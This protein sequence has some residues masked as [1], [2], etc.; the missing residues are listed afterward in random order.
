M[1]FALY[2]HER[3]VRLTPVISA[4]SALFTLLVGWTLLGV[5]TRL[6]TSNGQPV[7]DAEDA[8]L[9]LLL[10]L[11]QTLV[12][13]LPFLPVR[14]RVQDHERS[15]PVTRRTLVVVRI[16]ATWTA[17]VV[18]LLVSSGLILM[19][20]R[21]EGHA[22]ALLLP[23]ANLVCALTLVV[24]LAFAWK[25]AKER[26]SIL[27]TLGLALVAALVVYVSL[28][29]GLQGIGLLYLAASLVAAF[30]I[31]RFVPA[32]TAEDPAA[33]TTFVEDVGP[34]REP[35]LSPLTRTILKTTALRPFN[36][37]A[38]FF[39]VVC[40]GLI[41]VDNPVLMLW[42][43]I[44]LPIHVLMRSLTLL[45]GFDALPIARARLFPWIA[46]PTL[47]ALVV[48][49]LLMGV[50]PHEYRSYD[51]VANAVELDSFSEDALGAEG[52]YSLHVRTPPQLWQ[53][54]TT[55][56]ARLV[57]APW[58]ESFRPLPHAVLWG[59]PLVVF[60]PYD[61]GPQSSV[62]FLTWQLAR[63]LSVAH[64]LHLTPEDIHARWF[65]DLHPDTKLDDVKKSGLDP[66]PW[67]ALTA[68]RGTTSPRKFGSLV[69]LAV[70][71]WFLSTA[72]V[73]RRNVPARTLH[74]W[75]RARTRRIAMS[76]GLALVFVLLFAFTLRDD[77]LL[78]VLGALAHRS[79]DLALGTS[80]WAWVG[81][82]LVLAVVASLVLVWRLN[83][84]EVPPL[85]R[86]GWKKCEVSVF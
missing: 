42:F 10:P 29:G 57:E 36:V 66:Q 1:S 19:R 70:F 13:V 11:L 68:A 21:G 7:F 80:A 86:T 40:I 37:T 72:W 3:V 18:P 55:A 44:A 58:G 56:D 64:G 65:A 15:L 6:E 77:A 79:L 53:L 51:P 50:F 69:A 78:P 33:D 82:D 4:L 43:P 38:L 30:V 8:L 41:G 60:N 85:P 31:H 63:A 71:F 22:G 2:R 59:A 76:L 67:S 9:V 35:L 49:F 27:E 62:R 39:L 47:A 83:R 25:P 75:R 17:L 46:L 54:A 20:L 32:S 48:G 34:G 61:V 14:T 16:A 73:L 26:L 84:I 5:F 28:Y 24:L 23:V 52:E 74:L 81:F 12:F 45:N